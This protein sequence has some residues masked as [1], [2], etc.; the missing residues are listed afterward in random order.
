[1]LSITDSNHGLINPFTDKC[2]TPSQHHDLLIFRAIGQRKFLNRIASVTLKKPSVQ[3]P[4]RRHRLQTFSERK[5]NKS[6]VSQLEKDKKL[7]LSAMKKKIQ[8]S[9]RTGKPIDS[10]GEQLIE[11]P[12]AI[13]DNSGNP[14]KGQKSYTTQALGSRYKQASQQVLISE[15]PWKPECSVL[16]GMFLINTTPLGIHKTLADYGKFLISRFI[17]PQFSK[18]SL[19]VHIIFDNP[20]QLE[21]TPKYFEHL[22]RDASAKITEEHC[23]DELPTTNIPK[24]WREGLLNCRRCK[25]S[26]VLFLTDYFLNNI[27]TYLEAHQTLYV[28]GGFDGPTSDTAWYVRGKEQTST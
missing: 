4:N 11:Y 8:F 24:R 16:E 7:I 10:L 6:R 21:N 13:S 19:E 12:L 20:G 9:K 27:H 14:L 17:R 5:V 18:G 2:A 23:C 3:A 26:L 1:M 25:R 28:G 22:R 15:L